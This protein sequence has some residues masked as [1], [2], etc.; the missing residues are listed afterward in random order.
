MQTRDTP[1]DGSFSILTAAKDKAKE[2][3]AYARR[4]AALSVSFDPENAF[5]ASGAQDLSDRFVVAAALSSASDTEQADG[6]WR[7][8]AGARSR[9]LEELKKHDMLMDALAWRASQPEFD[10]GAS[11]LSDALSGQNEYG[12][13][14][15]QALLERTEDICDSAPLLERL[16]A[17]LTLAGHAAPAADRLPAV[18]IA[19]AAAVRARD[20]DPLLQYGVVGR[21]TELHQLVSHCRQAWQGGSRALFISGLGGVGKSTLLAEARRRLKADHAVV[22]H[23]DFDRPGLDGQDAV[24]LTLEVTRQIALELGAEGAPL[25][26]ARMRAAG[27]ESGRLKHERANPP[28]ALLQEAGRLVRRTGRPVLVLLDTIEV[29]AARGDEHP[30]AIFRS[31]EIYHEAGLGPLA[32]LAAG[33]GDAPPMIRD[34][35]EL[36]SLSGLDDASARELLRGAKVPSSAWP[37]LLTMARGNPMVLRLGARLV[38]EAGADA[39]T[40]DGLAHGASERI[41]AGQL[42]RLILSRIGDPKLRAIVHPG[43]LVRRLNAKMVLEVLSPELGMEVMSLDDAAALLD[44]LKRHS[45]LV[46]VDAGWISHRSDL[47]E[48]LLPL[49]TAADPMRARRLNCR[50]AHWFNERSEPWAAAEALYHRL[51]AARPGGR[52]P[53]IHPRTAAQ[54]NTTMLNELT[55]RA[56]DAVLLARGERSSFARMGDGP[57]ART[58]RSAK[59]ATLEIGT[60]LEKG[61]TLEATALVERVVDITSIDP[62]SSDADILLEAM[63]RGGDWKQ[64]RTLLTARDRAAPSWPLPDSSL[65]SLAQMQLRAELKP[66]AVRL[67]LVRHPEQASRM[68]EI[69]SETSEQGLGGPLTWLLLTAGLNAPR[70]EEAASWGLWTGQNGEGVRFSEL[71]NSKLQKVKSETNLET[72]LL[73]AASRLIQAS[74]REGGPP[75]VLA[76]TDR[77][78]MIRLLSIGSPYV[79]IIGERWSR[80]VADRQH[81]QPRLDAIT[82]LIP[83]C[84]RDGEPKDT[85]L[86]TGSFTAERFDARGRLSEW[87]G[88]ISLFIPSVDDKLLAR[89]VENRRRTL[90]GAWSYGELPN[91]WAKRDLDTTLKRRVENLLDAAEPNRHALERL[92]TWGELLPGKGDPAS[93]LLKRLEKTL[94]AVSVPLFGRRVE[95]VLSV[96]AGLARVEAPIALVPELA[97][98]LTEASTSLGPRYLRASVSDE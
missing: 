16:A 50:A 71:L 12:P 86:I 27:A 46:E 37:P 90:A 69:V 97:I 65:Q 75:R 44:E 70:T 19:A 4:Y 30:R 94:G 38:T 82:K 3:V 63:W 80:M 84:I 24:G 77:H 72:D 18:Q 73:S 28:L 29:L 88:A 81:L 48:L 20:P 11:Q 52:L 9:V 31:L 59:R 40:V 14:R 61:E 7:L 47:R 67:W 32:V 60:L 83:H 92:C 25:S 64:A 68:A 23:L 54:F 26:N 10:V 17:T 85:D 95:R 93:R 22:V 5:K 55:E 96:A 21:E 57:I 91:G 2:A 33:R 15:I 58:A 74:D 49:Q 8:R 79:R 42:Y 62:L 43:L 89:A 41:I 35:V 56:R 66:S 39:L 87:I 78:L 45:W 76:G 98:H 13:D 6:R 1:E 34:E 53:K 51:Q 36:L